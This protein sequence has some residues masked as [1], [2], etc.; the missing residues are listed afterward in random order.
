MH[1]FSICSRFLL[2]TVLHHS[3]FAG[4][5]FHKLERYQ[6]FFDDCEDNPGQGPLT[7][8]PRCTRLVTSLSRLATLKLPQIRELEVFLDHKEPDRLWAMHVTVNANLS[9]LKLLSFSEWRL[10]LR[11]AFH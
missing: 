7:E 2:C 8:M 4:Q 1:P 11:V 6:A 5:T 10:W 9:G 3:F